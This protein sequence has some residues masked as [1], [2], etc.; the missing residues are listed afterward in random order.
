MGKQVGISPEGL[1]LPAQESE[2]P[3]GN[4]LS[5]V[6]LAI[7][8]QDH[9]SGKELLLKRPAELPGQGELFFSKGLQV[10]FGCGVILRNESRFT[11]LGHN[12]P[13]LGKNHIGFSA[14]NMKFPEDVF[15]H[16]FHERIIISAVSSSYAAISTS[17]PI[18]RA[19]SPQ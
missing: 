16:G 2:F 17:W 7:G 4:R 9:R 5:R 8:S 12:Q 11:T 6:M 13:V 15:V 1:S 19:E 3:A 14:L 18:Q 10:P